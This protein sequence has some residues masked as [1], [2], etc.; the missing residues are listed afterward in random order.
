[1]AAVQ[2]SAATAG[3]RA[4]VPTSRWRARTVLSKTGS[5]PSNPARPRRSS[6]SMTRPVGESD[7]T[8]TAAMVSRYARRRSASATTS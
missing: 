4:G 5:R 3:V 2:P 8:L 6:A 7:V 1:M